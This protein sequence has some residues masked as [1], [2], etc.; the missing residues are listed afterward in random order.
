MGLHMEN[1]R[2]VYQGERIT[3][4]RVL[5]AG[6]AFDLGA[7]GTAQAVD[8][9]R[10]P[11]I[12]RAL[13]IRAGSRV[14]LNVDEEAMELTARCREITKWQVQGTRRPLRQGRRAGWHWKSL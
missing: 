10:A 13:Y 9:D 3:T 12:L 7:S 5:I 1:V 4:V 8:I 11:R 14:P 6:Q 2:A